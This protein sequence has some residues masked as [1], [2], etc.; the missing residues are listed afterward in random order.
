[1]DAIVASRRVA[2]RGRVV[3]VDFSPEM[4]SKARWAVAE[5]GADNVSIVAAGGEQLPLADGS[6]DVAMVNGIFNLNPYRDRL[7]HELARVLK[8]GGR[9]WSAEII[10]RETL[11]DA[12]KRSEAAWFA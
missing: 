8:P 1:M 2:D 6:I 7:F 11:A 10:L 5:C 12:H 4:V 3:G 9:V